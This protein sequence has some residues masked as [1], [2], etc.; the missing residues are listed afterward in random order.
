MSQELVNSVNKLTDETSALLQEYVKGNTV[1]QNSASEAASSADA[2]KVS[3]GITIDKANV[4]TQKAAEAKQFRDETAAVATGGTATLDPTPG[5]IPL[6]N[7]EAKIHAGWL[8]VNVSALS[9]AIVDVIRG[10]NKEQYAASGFVHFGKHFDIAGQFIPVNE[11]LWTRSDEPNKC[12]IGKVSSSKG[13]SKTNHAVMNIAGFIS[14]IIT[15]DVIEDRA[16]IKF[17]EAPNGTVVS[18]PSGNCRG[19]GKPTL[20][21][22]K[23]VDPKYGDVAGSVNEAV[24]RAFEGSV[25]NG[26]FRKGVAEWLPKRGATIN[27]SNGVITVTAGEEQFGGSASQL[28]ASS[29]T[30]GQKQTIGFYVVGV[31]PAQRARVAV[32]DR[33]DL[34]G[35]TYSISGY[36]EVG[37]HEITFTAATTQ[38][39]FHLSAQ[40]GVDGT[41]VQFSNISLKAATEEVVTERVD[42][43]GI[44]GYL[45]KANGTLYPYGCIQG[46]LTTV[47]GVATEIDN[48]RPITYFAAYDGDTSS[49]GRRWDLSKLTFVQLATIMSNPEHNAYYTKEGELV[50]FRVRQRTFAGVG[51]GDWKNVNSASNDYLQFNNVTGGAVRPQG[52]SDDAE[53]GFND[54]SNNYYRTFTTYPQGVMEQNKGLVGVFGVRNHSVNTGIAVNSECYFY[55][56]G[57]VPRLNQGA[58]HQSFNPMGT[59]QFAIANT[60]VSII[61]SYTPWYGNFQAGIKPTTQKD[62]FT[63]I[64]NT[65]EIAVGA[66]FGTGAIGQPSGRPDGKFYDAIYASGQGGVIDFRMSA[67]D[68]SSKEE[69]AKIFQKVVNGTYRGL[70]KLVLTKVGTV[71]H[72]GNAVYSDG[73]TKLI[74]SGQEWSPE[75]SD[76]YGITESGGDASLPNSYIVAIDGSVYPLGSINPRASSG[77]CY[78]SKLA[79]DVSAKFPAGTYNVVIGRAVGPSVS[80]DFSQVDV[81][82]SPAEILKVDALKNGWMGSWIPVIPNGTTKFFPLTRKH[83]GA[84]SGNPR[85]YSDNNGTSWT[86]AT[87]VYDTTKNGHQYAGAGTRVELWYYT[88]F[89]KQTKPSTNKPVLNG[90]EGV[91]LV[92]TMQHHD[93][94]EGC[95]LQESL[96]GKI[97]TTSAGLRY[98]DLELTTSTLIRGNHVNTGKLSKVEHEPTAITAP[99]NDS[100]AVKA[101]WYKTATN[102]QVGLNF[103]WNEM[104]WGAPTYTVVTDENYATWSAGTLY[105]IR[106]GWF[107]GFYR[108]EANSNLPVSW[109]QWV[110]SANHIYASTNGLRYFTKITSVLGGQGWADDSTI[111]ITDAISTYKNLHGTDCLYGI[112]DLAI[113]YGYVRG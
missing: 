14:N 29:A 11:G 15:N 18:D 95:L 90:S 1:L 104:V 35:G 70:E 73:Y 56:M 20:D 97:G 48:S 80:G 79:G 44:E 82:G 54:G 91:G 49:R 41:D 34:S 101:L 4:A 51:N 88:A 98:D 62:C 63:V 103:I 109:P 33:S 68:M 59:R 78:I 100:P 85:V 40:E 53:S 67:W 105:E 7:A 38:L 69:A 24:A 12:H 47:D 22:S 77:T 13:V 8:P 93:V 30:V 6:A 71:T 43:F 25:K 94:N 107:R 28:I 26:D 50:Q 32:S 42:M 52:S 108:C 110:E 84:A 45:E 89:A 86:S 74:V 46:Q 102:G 5:K 37:Y 57:T 65:E 23:E 61:N 17:S 27:A 2:A 87:I 60:G 31:N 64:K 16:A 96:T 3:E 81:I 9:E 76:W 99:N 75:F 19:T 66:H 106:V 111:R 36:Y 72:N 83:I 112:G 39:Y 92:S 58:Y 55:V 113:S 21:L 10:V